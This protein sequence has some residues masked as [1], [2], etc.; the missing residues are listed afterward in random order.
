MQYRSVLVLI[1]LCMLVSV[2]ASA[3]LEKVAKGATLYVGETNVDLS[4]A[5]DGGRQI[6]WFAPGNT[7]DD[8]ADIILTFT[9]S[10]AFSFNI[11]PEI[12]SNRTGTW[13][14]YYPKPRIPLFSVAKPSF[15]LSVWDLDHNRDVTGQPVPRSTNVTYRIDTNMYTVYNTLQRPD[16]NPQDTFIDV[17]L[18]GPT[19]KPINSIYT[20]SAGSSGV[21]IYPVEEHPVVKASPYYWKYGGVWNHSAKGYDGTVLYPLGTYTFAATQNLDNMEFYY[22]TSSSIIA[23]G[24]KTVTFVADEPAVVT[25]TTSTEVTVPGTTR[26]SEQTPSEA[27]MAAT[28]TKTVKPTWTS[29]PLSPQVTFIALALVSLV[30]LSR[31]RNRK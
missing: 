19:G 14:K 15:S 3:D 29:T 30:F 31:S 17:T 16:N 24:P 26:T 27:V 21:L 23:S 2:P 7:T 18:T 5:L 22:G 8:P 12:F 10:D 13:Y 28:T 25:T 6:A 11:S 1:I 20:A 4:S 9:E